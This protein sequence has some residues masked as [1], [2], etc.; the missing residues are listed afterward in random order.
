MSHKEFNQ[1]KSFR[2]SNKKDAKSAVIQAK[3]LKESPVKQEKE[4]KFLIK[5]VH[6]SQLTNKSANL[7]K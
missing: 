4:I 3:Y 6:A 1:Q 2:N 5:Q 7:E